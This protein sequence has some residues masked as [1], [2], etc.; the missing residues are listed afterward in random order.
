MKQVP[1]AV[2]P[3]PWTIFNKAHKQWIALVFEGL[4]FRTRRNEEF[5]DFWHLSI[6]MCV[7]GA[8]LI[9]QVGWT[10][11]NRDDVAIF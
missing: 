3:R 11:R 5:H 2:N 8:E 4:D 10:A 1:W 6:F 7:R 9:E